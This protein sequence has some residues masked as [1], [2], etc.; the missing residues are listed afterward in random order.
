MTKEDF[1]QLSELLGK[2]GDSIG[3]S[4]MMILTDY[5]PGVVA[6]AGFN[7]KGERLFFMTSKSLEE[8]VEKVRENMQEKEAAKVVPLNAV[9]NEKTGDA[10]N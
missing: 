1:T 2:L 5:S 9:P 10:V 4:K 6:L 3:T 7:E 8:A